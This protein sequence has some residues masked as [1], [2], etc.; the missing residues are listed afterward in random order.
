[1]G[2]VDPVGHTYPAVQSPQLV[3]LLELPYRPAGQGVHTLAPLREYQPGLHGL[4]T[5]VPNGQ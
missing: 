5:V 2:E 1:V 4:S 3:A